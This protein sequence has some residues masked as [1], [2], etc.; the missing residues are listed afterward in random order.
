[1]VCERCGNQLSEEALKCSKCGVAVTRRSIQEPVTSYGEFPQYQQQE[2]YALPS[3]HTTPIP[4]AE[5][6]IPM[7]EGKTYSNKNDSALVKELILSLFGVFGI[8][9]LSAG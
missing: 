7:R 3:Y 4:R 1:M 9:W 2:G 5:V 8:G 6:R